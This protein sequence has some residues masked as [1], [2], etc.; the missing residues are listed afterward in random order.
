MVVTVVDWLGQAWPGQDAPTPYTHPPTHL[1]MHTILVKYS[2]QNDRSHPIF[3]DCIFDT[4]RLEPSGL[5]LVF[6]FFSFLFPCILLKG[7]RFFVGVGHEKN[8][9]EHLMDEI[10]FT[11]GYAISE[12]GGSKGEEKSLNSTY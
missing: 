4:Q 8:Y 2:D 12:T 6:F 5:L 11:E 1:L 9:I 3:R 10:M 7:H